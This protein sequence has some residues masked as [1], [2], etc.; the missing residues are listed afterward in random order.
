M[1]VMNISGKVELL[2]MLSV[3]ELRTTAKYY[4]VKMGSRSIYAVMCEIEQR[5]EMIEQAK[6][7]WQKGRE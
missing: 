5:E 4:N 6:V 1:D 2:L 7:A 3:N